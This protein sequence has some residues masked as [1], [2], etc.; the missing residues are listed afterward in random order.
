MSS[1][2][3]LTN[4]AT[5]QAVKVPIDSAHGVIA[6]AAVKPLLV[7]TTNPASDEGAPLSLYDPGFTN[8]VAFRSRISR[9]DG[10]S[11]TL[12]Y[13][14][15]TIEDLVAHASF[16]EVAY[17]LIHGDLPSA[18]EY[19]AWQRQLLRHTYLHSELER[20]ML[21]FRWDAHPMGMLIAGL[22]ALSS[23]HPEAN[24]ALV[25]DSLYVS[26]PREQ[27]VPYYKL[28]GVT[29]SNGPEAEV[30]ALDVRDHVR[31]KQVYRILGKLPTIAANV[32][33]H[34]EG[35]PY[36]HPMPSP[37][38]LTEN[39]M[40]ML[41]KLNEEEYVPD[42]T[43]VSI[44]DRAFILLAEHGSAC[45]TVAM[46]HL[47]SSGVDPFT[48]TA[49]ACGTLFGERK[50]G[51]VVRMLQTIDTVADVLPYLDAVKHKRATFDRADGNGNGTGVAP[52]LSRATTAL[53]TPETPKGIPVPT[54]PLKLM[55]FGHRIYKVPDPRVAIMRDLVLECYRHIYHQ[56]PETQV[57][58]HLVH[59]GFKLEEA[60]G[61]DGWFTGRKIFANIDF[62]TGLLLHTMGFPHDMFPVI[63]AI[64]RSTG[65]LAHFMEC[66]D[67]KEPI[68]RPRQVYTGSQQRPYVPLG[69]R[70]PLSPTL[71]ASAPLSAVHAASSSS[72]MAADGAAAATPA[73][74]V[75][76]ADDGLD[77]IS[78]RSNP[79]AQ[80]RRSLHEAATP[81]D[82]AAL[83]EQ[84]RARISALAEEVAGE[85]DRAAGGPSSSAVG[86]PTPSLAGGDAATSGNTPKLLR[87][88]VS[89]V[90]MRVKK[91]GGGP[92]SPPLASAVSAEMQVAQMERI[93]ER[94]LELRELLDVQREMLKV[95]ANL[96]RGSHVTD[97][98]DLSAF[99][100]L[101]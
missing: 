75:T 32:F 2:L 64:P 55:G 68:Y 83:I 3:T 91:N 63:M 37:R 21:T 87:R 1:T 58:G 96:A 60:V 67:A 82:V 22:S 10:T 74:A 14:G 16:T 29:S 93:G 49:G 7:R 80:L 86:T 65:Y 47:V 44:L 92:S 38:S 33:R 69:E 57:S 4:T 25:G 15:Y 11:G 81:Q 59:L 52:A 72:A 39:F 20:Q 84:T 97:E 95:R 19:E 50:A 28:G 100:R 12:T 41:D 35:R 9:V 34:R 17:L 40:Y 26:G 71:S 51:E 76:G 30:T 24:P 79:A 94:S 23:F 88:L 6:A 101:E 36:N 42:K 98:V 31:V 27:L 62:Y 13:R 85:L 90:Q 54:A 66:V 77:A 8:T 18:R 89:A 73:A 53:P 45:S 78:V 46:R 70:V 5:G 99:A 56:D 61:N 48:A 43:L